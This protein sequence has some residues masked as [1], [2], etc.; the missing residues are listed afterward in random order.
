[1]NEIERALQELGRRTR[2]D[3]PRSPLP[4]GAFRR[5][6]LRR[7]VIA[8][9][10]ALSV[11]LA[12]G[13]VVYASSRMGE[14][15]DLPPANV[16]PSPTEVAHEPCGYP[17]SFHANFIPRGLGTRVHPGGRSGADAPGII[18]HYEGNPRGALIEVAVAGIS[19]FAQTSKERI[20]V[21]G[22]TGTVGV[23]HEGFSVEFD[24]A[25]CSYELRAYGL[26]EATL[27]RFAEN[28]VPRGGTLEAPFHSLW[29]DHTAATAHANCGQ[30]DYRLDPESVALEFGALVME[31]REPIAIPL[32]RSATEWSGELRKSAS[33]DGAE[34]SGPAIRIWVNEAF[35]GCWSVTTVARHPDREPT[36]M[37]VGVAGRDFELGFTP[38]GAAS[39]DI[40]VGYGERTT[41]TVWKGGDSFVHI[42]LP[43]DPDAPGHVLIIL[44]DASGQ[45]FSAASATFPQG[46]FVAG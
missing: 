4:G 13:G 32:E 5:I 16:S 31:W 23:I 35:P 2:G 15:R 27:R 29:P 11:L 42:D 44:R 8:G 39:A 3:V 36:G 1:M 46:D 30:Q 19:S 17:L 34:P 40:E 26:T 38:L 18:A 10:T 25:G 7:A 28:L 22:S 45:P 20:G 12:V 21:L 24:Y 33:D 6:K 43:F 9:T 37:S 41:S 14:E